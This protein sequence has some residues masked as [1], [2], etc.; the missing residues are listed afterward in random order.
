MGTAIVYTL[1]EKRE[2]VSEME[3]DWDHAIS[4]YFGN[5]RY[6]VGVKG[7]PLPS[8][9]TSKKTKLYDIKNPTT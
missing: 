4:R 2:V 8:N 3:M 5:H 6:Y 9:I 7:K 1:N